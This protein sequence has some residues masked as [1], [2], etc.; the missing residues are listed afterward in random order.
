MCVDQLFPS[1]RHAGFTLEQSE[2]S[3]KSLHLGYRLRHSYSK[4]VITFWRGGDYPKLH[5]VLRG[6][7]EV[8][9]LFEQLFYGPVRSRVMGMQWL[10]KP[11]QDIGIGKNRHSEATVF[12]DRA[13][14][15]RFVRQ[16]NHY[17]TVAMYPFIISA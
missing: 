10:R 6:Q 2:N 15:H 14:L 3:P 8:G 7:T 9:T 12:V 13:A 1:G 5:K 17:V 11:Q 4:A 16:A